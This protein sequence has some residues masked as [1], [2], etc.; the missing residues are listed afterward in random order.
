V[1]AGSGEH[2]DAHTII[3]AQLIEGYVEFGD[4]SLVKGVEGNRSAVRLARDLWLTPRSEN[5]GDKLKQDSTAQT[6]LN[7]HLFSALNFSGFLTTA[8]NRTR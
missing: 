5:P 7:P 1:L 8:H 3:A 6:G 4:H 2:D